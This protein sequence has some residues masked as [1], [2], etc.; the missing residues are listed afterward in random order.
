MFDDEDKMCEE[1]RRK[2]A[3]AKAH[4]L[5]PYSE[6]AELKKQLNELQS[7]VDN[8]IKQKGRYNTEIAYKQL[9]DM[10][11]SQTEEK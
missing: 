10:Y 6:I 8:L 4:G 3:P 7:T 1:I 11:L 2:Q 9:V 5:V